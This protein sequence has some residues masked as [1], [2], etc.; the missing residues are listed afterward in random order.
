[1][2]RDVG[3]HGTSAIGMGVVEVDTRLCTMVVCCCY[4]GLM[5]EGRLLL[6]RLSAHQLILDTVKLRRVLFIQQ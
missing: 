6:G 1:M 2:N 4:F 3:L 5:L